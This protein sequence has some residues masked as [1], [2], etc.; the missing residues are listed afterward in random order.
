[1]LIG[2]LALFVFLAGFEAQ[3]GLGLGLGLGLVGGVN[4]MGSGLG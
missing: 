2:E 4:I 3:T 1:M